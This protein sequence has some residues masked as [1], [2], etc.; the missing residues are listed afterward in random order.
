MSDLDIYS[1]FDHALVVTA[2]ISLF[3]LSRGHCATNV[4]LHRF[5]A[6]AR[7]NCCPTQRGKLW[8]RVSASVP[9]G[10]GAALLL[11]EAWRAAWIVALESRMAEVP[12]E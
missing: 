8:A 7:H 1:I 10:A 11:V 3:A 5:S 2:R 12:R 9:A 6:T 4:D